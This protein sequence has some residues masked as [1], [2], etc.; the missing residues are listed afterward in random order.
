MILKR[1][2]RNTVFGMALG[3]NYLLGLHKLGCKCL[4][5]FQ[6]TKRF[7]HYTSASLYVFMCRDCLIHI[8]SRRKNE[9][10]TKTKKQTSGI[11]CCFYSLHFSKFYRTGT[12]PTI[13][14]ILATNPLQFG[15]PSTCPSQPEA[16]ES[17]VVETAACPQWSCVWSSI[18]HQTHLITCRT[19][20]CLLR[21]P[22][23]SGYFNCWQMC[24]NFDSAV[25]VVIWFQFSNLCQKCA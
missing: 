8:N 23:H 5:E 25:L 4:S 9:A 21:K 10:E 18:I 7:V 6:L 20:W 11:F 19:K 12:L 15:C 17:V 1:Q 2:S 3:R 13:Y 24:N 22:S 14:L 16:S